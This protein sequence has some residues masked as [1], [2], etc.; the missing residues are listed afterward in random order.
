MKKLD[1]TEWKKKFLGIKKSTLTPLQK[2][3]KNNNITL[4]DFWFMNRE[5]RR[6]KYYE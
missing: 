2:R 5:L 6:T 1:L 4:D 3:K